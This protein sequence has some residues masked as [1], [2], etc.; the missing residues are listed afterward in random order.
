MGKFRIIA[1]DMALDLV[2]TVEPRIAGR[3][4]ERDHLRSTDALLHWAQRADVVDPSQSER[5]TQAWV[6]RPEVAAQELEAVLRLRTAVGT[7]V[8]AA[9][10][11]ARSTTGTEALTTVLQLAASALTR[12]ELVL[13]PDGDQPVRRLVGS[14]PACLIS[15]RLAL[16][17]LDMLLKADLHRLKACPPEQGGCGWVFLDTSKSGTRRWCSMEDCGTQVKI[18]RL[19]ERRRQQRTTSPGDA[20]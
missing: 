14:R 2:N 12:A 18:R 8:D 1:G 7:A 9:R 4:P 19:T 16:D 15:D 6:A 10:T 13:D 11:G 20:A 17:A 3:E 5:I